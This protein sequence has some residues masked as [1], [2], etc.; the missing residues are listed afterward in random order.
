[1]KF[2]SWFLFTRYSLIVHCCV[3]Q[4]LSQV[5]HSM[6]I[7]CRSRFF[8][9]HMLFILCSW[10]LLIVCSCSSL[11]HGLHTALPPPYTKGMFKNVT[12]DG[13]IRLFTV[14]HAGAKIFHQCMVMEIN[15][16][17]EASPDDGAVDGAAPALED[18]MLALT[19]APAAADGHAGRSPTWTLLEPM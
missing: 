11:V 7:V 2:L 12:D 6:F 10:L 5:V 15:E 19:D 9:C 4:C 17:K 8:F 1:M 18:G 13:V 14:V 16:I 3:S